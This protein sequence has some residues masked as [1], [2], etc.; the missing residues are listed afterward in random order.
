MVAAGERARDQPAAAVEHLVALSQ[1]GGN[2]LDEAEA[3]R[4]PLLHQHVAGGELQRPP[5]DMD[6]VAQV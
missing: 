1:V 3:A 2:G 4:L 6:G 5:I